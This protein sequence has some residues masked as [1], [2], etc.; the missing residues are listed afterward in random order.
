VSFVPHYSNVT[1]CVMQNETCSHALFHLLYWCTA[2]LEQK[3]QLCYVHFRIT[4]NS[5]EKMG[6]VM[7]IFKRAEIAPED[8]KDE[9]ALPTSETWSNEGD[10]DWIDDPEPVE[11]SRTYAGPLHNIVQ[12]FLH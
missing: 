10:D 1:L 7:K 6:N 12:Q 11:P 5:F 8:L 4:T 2:V 3:A 9:E